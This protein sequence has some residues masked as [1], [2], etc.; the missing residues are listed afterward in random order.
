[1]ACRIVLLTLRG[2]RKCREE[3]AEAIVARST[4]GE[5]PNLVL[6]TGTFAVRVS[7]DIEGRA[8]M[9]GADAAGTGR[10]PEEGRMSMS[11][12]PWAE[13]SSVPEQT[14]LM[15]RVVERS[16]MQSAYSRVKQNKGAPGVDGMKVEQL[17]SFLRAH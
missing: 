2:V 17:G 8:G 16:N 12:H 10:N 11:K 14:Q 5:G 15:E 9:R 7:G 1:M 6:R 3:S 4:T 13:G